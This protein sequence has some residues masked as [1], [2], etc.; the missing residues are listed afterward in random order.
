MITELSY[1]VLTGAN[2]LRS[3]RGCYFLI[4]MNRACRKCPSGVH[5]T[6]STS[7]ASSGRTHTHSFIFSA[8]RPSPHR[9]ERAS[10]RFANGHA[11]APGAA[12]APS[13]APGSPE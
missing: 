7:A 11:G 10:G 4:P 2:W 13:A 9:P 6:N 1:L 5:S 12:A 3:F 8:V